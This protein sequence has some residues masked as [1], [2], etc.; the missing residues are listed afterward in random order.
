MQNQIHSKMYGWIFSNLD[1]TTLFFGQGFEGHLELFFWF[2][3]WKI[4]SLSTKKK[5]PGKFFGTFFSR[6]NSF[7]FSQWPSKETNKSQVQDIPGPQKIWL[8][9]HSAVSPR[10]DILLNFFRRWGCF[11]FFW[12][13]SLLL[14]VSKIAAAWLFVWMIFKTISSTWPKWPLCK[15][16]KTGRS[17]SQWES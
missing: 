6:S 14:L 13:S 12:Y 8:Q 5:S 9:E 3:V 15:P 10:Y 7:A 16:F 17:L 4:C 11:C 2:K 1:I